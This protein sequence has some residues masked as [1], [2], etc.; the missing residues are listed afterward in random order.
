LGGVWT[1]EEIEQLRRI[2]LEKWD[3]IGVHAFAEPGDDA[4]AYWDEY[5]SYMPAILSDLERGGDVEWLSQYL[6]SR[7]TE[8]MGLDDRPDLDR[9]AAEFIVAWNPKRDG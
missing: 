5:D 6:A 4:S 9:R 2:L 1:G 8:A 7:R 3:P